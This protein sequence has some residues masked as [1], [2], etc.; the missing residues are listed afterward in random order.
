MGVELLAS[1]KCTGIRHSFQFTISPLDVSTQQS[2]ILTIPESAQ[3]KFQ[4]SKFFSHFI[5]KF[6]RGLFSGTPCMIINSMR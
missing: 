4:F 5:S 6:C 1:K 3:A 2:H